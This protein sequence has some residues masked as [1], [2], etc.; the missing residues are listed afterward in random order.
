MH[1]SSS[2]NDDVNAG[3]QFTVLLHI[4][5]SG[6]TSHQEIVCENALPP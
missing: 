2:L 3:P 1:R 4:E 5:A 6:V